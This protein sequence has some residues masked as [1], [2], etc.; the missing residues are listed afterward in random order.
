MFSFFEQPDRD[1]EAKL[2]KTKPNLG[3]MGHLRD[4]AS[5]RGQG[6]RTNPISGARP[7][8]VG[9]LRKTKP[10]WRVHQRGRVPLRTNKANSARTGGRVQGL[11]CETNPICS[12]VRELTP[13]RRALTL[14]L[15]CETKPIHSARERSPVGTPTTSIVR[16]KA[17]LRGEAQRRKRLLGKEL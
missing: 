2:R 6:R 11:S 4:G 10:I 8:A 14:G 7:G 1:P 3:G 9:Q 13:D 5:G 17:N 12:G 16:N 15:S